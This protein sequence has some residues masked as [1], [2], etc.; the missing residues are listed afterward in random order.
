M[1]PREKILS[2]N[3]VNTTT[4]V[5]YFN[6]TELTSIF[7]NNNELDK[8][9]FNNVL[10]FE[11]YVE[12]TIYKRRIDIGDDLRNKTIEIIPHTNT[13]YQFLRDYI[14]NNQD[15]AYASIVTVENEILDPS[16][17]KGGYIGIT[18]YDTSGI[19][20]N[21]E[22][23]NGS[24]AVNFLAGDNENNI[25]IKDKVDIPFND[26]LSV[27]S[28]INDVN[29]VY[30]WLYIEDPNIRPLQVGDNV[31]ENTKLYFNFSDDYYKSVRRSEYIVKINTITN[32]EFGIISYWSVS[33]QEIGIGTVSGSHVTQH[34]SY[35][36]I[37]VEMLGRLHLNSSFSL[38]GD[39]SLDSDSQF[40]GTVSEINL[41]SEAY[42]YILVDT[43][44]LG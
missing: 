16:Y 37:W 26:N 2:G 38:A 31:V 24:G 23:Y 22:F 33:S 8:V 1:T 7:Y 3:T 35:I 43:T 15:T 19:Q 29:P 42:N 44:T 5:T 39:L 30:R 25:E 41:N 14:D 6:N 12:P 27:I 9:Y 10:V 34:G 4:P 18:E 20:L 17:Q 11:K 32:E 28:A 36:Y 21:Y 13:V 40:I